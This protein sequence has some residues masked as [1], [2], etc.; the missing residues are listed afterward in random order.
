MGGNFRKILNKYGVNHRVA[1][2]YHPQTS[3][4]V[5]LSNKKIKTIL[6]KTVNTSR[7]D[8][9]MRINDSLRHIALHP[10]PMGTTPYKMFY[11]KACHLPLE[12]EHRAFW[13]IKKFNYDFKATGEKRLLDIQDLDELRCEAYESAR[14]FKEKVKRWHDKKIQKKESKQGDKVLLFNSRLKLSAGKLRSK[15]EGPYDVEEANP[16]SAAKLK[17]KSP[18]SSWIVNDQHLKHYRVNKVNNIFEV[19]MVS[20][21]E[22]IEDTHVTTYDEKSFVDIFAS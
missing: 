21:E 12:L 19:R 22:F 15:W 14:L 17:G 20:T 18:S 10:N 4:Q 11:G 5:D 2:P 8:W 6:Q 9:S 1:T 13:A 3:G 16:S 7:K